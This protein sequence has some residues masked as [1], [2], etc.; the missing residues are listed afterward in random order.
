MLVVNC[1]D[2]SG[3]W[4]KPADIVTGEIATG[5]TM[6][7]TAKIATYQFPDGTFSLQDAQDGEPGF[8]SY[9]HTAGFMLA[10]FSKTITAELA[11]HLNSGSLIIGEM[12]DG[13]YSLVGATDN[14]LYIKAAFNSGAKGSDKRGYTLKA[15]QDGF[16]WGVLPIKS[17]VVTAL[18]LL[19]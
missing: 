11:K 7:A 5:P 16:M 8:Q 3:V 19:P 12:N 6:V 2:I 9:K 14:P 15:E 18:T 17:T 13:Q 1:K 10:G 4:P